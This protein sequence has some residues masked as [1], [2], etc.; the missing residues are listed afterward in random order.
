MTVK[1]FSEKYQISPQAVYAKIRKKK[2]VLDGHITKSGG[3]LVIDEYAEELLKPKCANF[4]LLE[5]IKNLQNQLDVKISECE[6]LKNSLDAEILKSEKLQIRLNDKISENDIL[7]KQLAEQSL[8]KSDFDNFAEMLKSEILKISNKIDD[9]QNS[10]FE[11]TKK[12][13]NGIMGLLKK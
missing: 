7:Q 10:I 3:Q 11:I 6:K 9:T 8:K 2:N 4:T 13:G 5:K 12:S 1:G